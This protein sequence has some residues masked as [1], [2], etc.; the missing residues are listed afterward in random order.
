MTLVNQAYASG[1]EREKYAD[2]LKLLYPFAPHIAEELYQ[3]NG[4]EGQ[5]SL[6]DWPQ[7]NYKETD[8]KMIEI[9]IQ[10]NGK[11]RGKISVPVGSTQDYVKQVVLSDTSLK[12]QLQTI[13]KEIFVNDKIYNFIV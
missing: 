5:L 1:I 6:S 2:L 7:P 11:V 10:I 13:K 12:A 9:P 8:I 3:I 4:F